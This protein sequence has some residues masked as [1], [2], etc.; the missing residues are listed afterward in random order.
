M[1]RCAHPRDE[2]MLGTLR[3]N[4][5]EASDSPSI[6]RPRLVIGLT[7][8]IG[9]G[10]TVVANLFAAR[11]VPV[12]DAD[13]L[14]RE[15]VEPG[16]PAFEA[17]VAEFGAGVLSPSGALDRR[18]LRERVFADSGGRERLE[19]I[20]HPRVYAEMER[21]LDSLDDG[22]YA[23]VVVP[24]LVETGGV[25]RVDRVLVVDA[26]EALQ[27]ERVSRR[28]GTSRA[29]VEKILAAQAER[30][31]RL[32][33]ADDVIVNDADESQLERRVETLHEEY[34]GRAGR[35][36]SRRPEMKE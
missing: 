29:A 8:G 2:G 24:L 12:I 1:D 35:V 33:A 20:I 30:G 15:V 23:V 11:G 28:D 3:A 17:I 26:P 22:P 25:E 31:A 7:G 9:T 4:R 34:L 10:K 13:V 27:I 21:R 19:A 18:R 6:V 16:Q 14:A 32:E 5:I 36:A